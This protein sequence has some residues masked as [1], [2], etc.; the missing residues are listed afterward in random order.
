MKY[1]LDLSNGLVASQ[2]EEAF[3]ESKYFRGIEEL[4]VV[5]FKYVMEGY[6]WYQIEDEICLQVHLGDLLNI[7]HPSQRIFWL[8]LQDKLDKDVDA[9]N[10][11]KEYLN[12]LHSCSRLSHV[13]GCQVGV[14]VG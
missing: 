14:D 7:A 1:Q 2:E 13:K 6:K 5:A 10:H 9:A 11:F 3:A 8:V 4:D 12:S